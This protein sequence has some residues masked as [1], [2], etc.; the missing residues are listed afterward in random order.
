LKCIY[1]GNED[2]DAQVHAPG[3]TLCTLSEH[4]VSAPCVTGLP[5]SGR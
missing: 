4:P 3:A 1:G 5:G 2:M